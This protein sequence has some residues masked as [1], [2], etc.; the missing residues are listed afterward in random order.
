MLSLVME[1]MGGTVYL[2]QI[3]TEKLYVDGKAGEFGK[4]KNPVRKG[5]VDLENRTG[6]V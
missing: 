4:S 1:T 5:E 3:D 6:K 2:K